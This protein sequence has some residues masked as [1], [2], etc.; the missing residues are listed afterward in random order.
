MKAIVDRNTCVGCG[1]CADLCPAVFSMDD[2][3]VSVPISEDIP[4]DYLSDAE[5]AME[6]CPVAAITIE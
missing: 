6:Q 1:L 4:S 2:E 5:Q 3:G